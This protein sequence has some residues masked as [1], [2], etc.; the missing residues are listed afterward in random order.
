MKSHPTTYLVLADAM[1]LMGGL[2]FTR[3]IIRE[4]PG[5]GD[6]WRIM[7]VPI[8]FFILGY[9]VFS[10]ATFGEPFNFITLVVALIFCGGGGFAA[11]VILHRI[12]PF[13]IYPR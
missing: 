10:V 11:T 1:L 6:R 9:P 7:Y 8:P 13:E 3:K 5:S 2:Y 12:S 4:L